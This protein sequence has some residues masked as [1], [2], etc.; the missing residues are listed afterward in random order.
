MNAMDQQKVVLPPSLITKEVVAKSNRRGSSSQVTKARPK[1]R[2]KSATLPVDVHKLS[3]E[4][5]VYYNRNQRRLV[6]KS[7][8][9]KITL[10]VHISPD[11]LQSQVGNRAMVR[12]STQNDHE[13][14]ENITGLKT[15]F[16]PYR[17]ELDET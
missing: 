10:E 3:P 9:K 4:T 2:L 17:K 12:K 16:T 8:S 13:F 1:E 5:N 11:Q 7:N 6:K 15:S 14:L